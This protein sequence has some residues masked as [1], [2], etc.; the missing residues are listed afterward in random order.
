M[1]RD[2]TSSTLLSHREVPSGSEGDIAMVDFVLAP[3]AWD[4]F[5]GRALPEPTAPLPAG[6]AVHGARWWFD[7]PLQT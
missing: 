1:I 3:V 7:P 5:A 6:Q 4:W 2:H